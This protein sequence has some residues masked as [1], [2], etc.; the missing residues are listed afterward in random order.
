MLVISPDGDETTRAMPSRQPAIDAEVI[1]R[2]P[3]SAYRLRKG[4]S[5]ALWNRPPATTAAEVT[6]V[7]S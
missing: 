7:T 6:S 4:P 5:A 3:A 1:D 2:P